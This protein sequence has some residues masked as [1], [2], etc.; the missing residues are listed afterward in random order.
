MSATATQT[1]GIT[2]LILT[3]DEE[4]RSLLQFA[5][6]GTG[7]A[8]TLNVV[9]YPAN[10]CDL[11]LRQIQDAKADVL[12]VDIPR[13][14]PTLALRAVD[15]LHS[16]VP[17][18]ALFAAGDVNQPQVIIEAMRAGAR[19][20]IPRPVQVTV[21]LEAFARLA[22]SQRRAPGADQR[23]AV[24]AVVDAKGGAGA[25]TVAVNLAVAL[26]GLQGSTVLVDL[27]SLGHA[28][29]HLNVKPTFTVLDAIANLHRLD[30]SLLEGFL[31]RC[32][33]GLQLL[34][35][36]KEPLPAE[37]AATDF[38][39]L[40]GVLAAHYRYV[41][42]D[43]STRY[44]SSTRAVCDLS[45]SVLLV[46][47]ADVASLWSAA[48]VHSFLRENGNRDK[49]RLVLNRYRKIGGFTDADV[50]AL[51]STKLLWKLPNQYA[52]ISSCIDRG[53]PVAQN[54][55]N[56]LATSFVGLASSLSG[57][58]SG[59]KRKA[60]GFLSGLRG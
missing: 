14:N 22:S 43:C 21:L 2:V 55:H 31:T 8:R 25:T 58:R 46:T 13:E 44:D 50:E 15:L 24:Y 18:S 32:A 6:E 9:A 30:A 33:G 1:S 26:Q 53:I 29:L 12:L 40:L 3:V 57:A 10:P 36:I 45:D 42:V 35:G 4:Q 51:T 17:K 34:A 49:V 7:L 52:L 11:L 27:A 59:A 37:T 54:N 39:R 47:H 16:E 20:F 38:A 60:F 5:V 56:E 28:A 41:V 48:Q 19:E 23:G